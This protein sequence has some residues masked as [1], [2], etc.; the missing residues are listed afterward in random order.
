MQVNLSQVKQIKKPTQGPGKTKTRRSGFFNPEPLDYPTL[1]C[2]P[3]ARRAG[4][5]TGQRFLW[6]PP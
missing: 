3:L 5:F 6:W 2:G 1:G 4:A